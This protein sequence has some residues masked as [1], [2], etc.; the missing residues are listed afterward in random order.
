MMPAST[1]CLLAFILAAVQATASAQIA[2]DVASIKQSKNLEAGGT[3]GI[4]AGGQFF[5]VNAP[6]RA[7]LTYAFN[8]PSYKV[9]GGPDWLRTDRYD[10]DTRANGVPTPQE[11]REMVKSLLAERCKLAFHWEHRELD[12]FALVSARPGI[13]GPQLSSSTVDC[14]R[15]F[16]A[17]PR[18]REGGL[19]FGSVHT[20]NVV[21]APMSIIV[22][23]AESELA[24][25]VLDDTQ[26]AG[27]FDVELRW[28]PGLPSPDDPPAL[29]TALQ[30][31]LGLKLEQRRVPVD[32]LVID[33]MER[34][35][36]D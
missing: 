35:T 33:R 15:D 12:G 13:Q 6:L 36:P 17:T 31:Q 29:S 16:A 30:E 24:A 8:L 20:L 23:V 32:V 11:A 14:L 9:V 21:G 4:R 3:V 27:T 10:V 22:S 2:F 5:A 28:T 34:P 1:R 18:C 19:T 7:A 25:P 26:L